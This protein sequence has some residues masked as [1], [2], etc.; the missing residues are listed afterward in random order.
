[1]RTYRFH[2]FQHSQFWRFPDGSFPVLTGQSLATAL[3][4]AVVRELVASHR[5]G[6]DVEVQLDRATHQAAL[7]EIEA[8][9]QQ[10]GFDTAQALITEWATSAVTGAL[11]GTVGG[12]VA[13]S[14]TK[15]PASILLVAAIG[16]VVGSLV[17]MSMHSIRATFQAHRHPFGG[18]W[19]IAPN[20][21]TRPA[22]GMRPYPP[23][24]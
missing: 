4:G 23:F 14:V 18:G 19:Q 22:L 9:L 21:V 17:G 20:G 15:D 3:T 2:A 6:Y 1:M 10:L 24:A 12:G 5:G 16:L 7:A 8:A 11:F 13:G